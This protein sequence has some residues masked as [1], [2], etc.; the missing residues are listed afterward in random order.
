MASMVA[1]RTADCRVVLAVV[2]FL[3]PRAWRGEAARSRGEERP[4]ALAGLQLGALR[5]E[6]R[7]LLVG[8]ADAQDECV[9]EEPPGDHEPSGQPLVIEPVRHAERGLV[10]VVED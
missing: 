6:V 9:L 4:P 8:M 3:Q 2:T 10:R 5:V 1:A 7:R